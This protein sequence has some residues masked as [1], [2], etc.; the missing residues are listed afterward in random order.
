MAISQ[1]GSLSNVLFETEYMERPYGTIYFDGTEYSF[2]F[3]LNGCENEMSGNNI[4]GCRED[5]DH[6]M[7]SA[8]AIRALEEIRA[9]LVPAGVPE[10]WLE[11]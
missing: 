2:F 10:K 1:G 3:A 8:H 6:C 5:Y 4:D 9:I 11:L 7:H